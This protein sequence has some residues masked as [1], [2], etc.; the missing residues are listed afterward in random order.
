MYDYILYACYKT[1]SALMIGGLE[2]VGEMNLTR[3]SAGFCND[4][5]LVSIDVPNYIVPTEEIDT[6]LVEPGLLRFMSLKD[7]DHSEPHHSCFSDSSET[8]RRE[9]VVKVFS[10]VCGCVVLSLL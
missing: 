4:V 3:L 8:V 2:W 7:L 5:Y 6:N 1:S 9:F 10:S